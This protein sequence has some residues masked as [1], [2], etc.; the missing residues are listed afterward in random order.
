MSNTVSGSP[1]T[2]WL[3]Y[4][5]IEHDC[6]H[7]DCPDV[8]WC[9]DAQFDSDVMYVRADL[10]EIEQLKAE[11]KRLLAE[12]QELIDAVAAIQQQQKE[13]NWPVTGGLVAALEE[14]L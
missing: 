10:T 12:R 4:G 3:V 9:K 14:K 8:T 5:D 1:E 11:N 6:K 7:M 2:I 13:K